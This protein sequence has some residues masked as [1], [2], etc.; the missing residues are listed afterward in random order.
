MSSQPENE[1]IHIIFTYDDV[2]SM[3]DGAGID[4]EVACERAERW[5]PY[6]EDT[7]MS[8][9]SDQLYSCVEVDSP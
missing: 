3:A 7:A 1:L 4:F 8:L 2:L 9:I 5:A 6:I